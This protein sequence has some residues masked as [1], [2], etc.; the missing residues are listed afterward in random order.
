MIF[1]QPVSIANWH[2]PQIICEIWLIELLQIASSKVY[3]LSSILTNK[4]VIK[5]IM[6][7]WLHFRAIQKIM[8]DTEIHTSTALWLAF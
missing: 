3:Q 4:L 7:P 8:C 5:I 6:K 1:D 2:K